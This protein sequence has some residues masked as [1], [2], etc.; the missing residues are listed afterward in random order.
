MTPGGGD[1]AEKDEAFTFVGTAQSP[2]DDPQLSTIQDT[3]KTPDAPEA[4]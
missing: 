3:V 2:L 1:G 4:T